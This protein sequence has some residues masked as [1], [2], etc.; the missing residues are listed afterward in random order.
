MNKVKTL[1]L[2]SLCVIFLGA[3]GTEETSTNDPTAKKGKSE[4]IIP[5]EVGLDKLDKS[6]TDEFAKFDSDEEVD[7]EKINLNKR[8]FKEYVAAMEEQE[9]QDSGD[10]EDSPIIISSLMKDDRTIEMI[11]SNS[12]KSEMSELTNGF[13]TIIMD[14]FTRQLYLNSDFSDGTTQPT[15]LIKDDEGTI[16]SEATDFIETEETE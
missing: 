13:F 3:C 5:K 2:L 7:W 8:Q 11:I 12:D 4:T 15:I 1:V 16:I 6:T 14:T 10:N 9:N